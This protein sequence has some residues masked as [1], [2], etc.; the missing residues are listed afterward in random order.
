MPGLVDSNFV[1]EGPHACGPLCSQEINPWPVRAVLGFSISYE[2]SILAGR[3]QPGCQ[4]RLL[5]KWRMGEF[6]RNICGKR[7]QP[8]RFL[9]RGRFSLSNGRIIIGFQITYNPPTNQG[10]QGARRLLPPLIPSL[11]TNLERFVDSISGSPGRT[12]TINLVVNSHPLCR[13]SYRGPCVKR[14]PSLTEGPMVVNRKVQADEGL[15]RSATVGLPNFWKT[16]RHATGWIWEPPLSAPTPN[17]LKPQRSSSASY[18]SSTR[19]WIFWTST[20]VRWRK[21]RCFLK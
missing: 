1:Q 13:L 19:F 4:T 14:R 12:R 16:R 6:G 5:E 20:S 15:I 2:A 10:R 3:R 7:V 9:P 18:S 21:R 11:T 17:Y 8:P